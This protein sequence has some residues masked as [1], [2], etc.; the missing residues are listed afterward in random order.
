[1]KFLIFC[2]SL[3]C[4]P[5]PFSIIQQSTLWLIILLLLLPPNRWIF[6]ILFLCFSDQRWGRV[7]VRRDPLGS[8]KFIPCVCVVTVHLCQLLC[9]LYTCTWC[10][11]GCTCLRLFAESFAQRVRV[12]RTFLSLPAISK[13]V[14]FHFISGMIADWAEKKGKVHSILCVCKNNLIYM[15]LLMRKIFREALALH[16]LWHTKTHSTVKNAVLRK[17]LV[18][19]YSI[20]WQ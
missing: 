6:M 15:C 5:L 4:V 17:S 9:C 2:F 16:R 14:L 20:I 8:G 1:M 19:L 3:R 10:C 7:R 11:V 18:N 13:E 12:T